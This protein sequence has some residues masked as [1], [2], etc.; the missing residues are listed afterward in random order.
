M[1][2]LEKVPPSHV[3]DF[4]PSGYNDPKNPKK[5][6]I[7][8]KSSEQ[9]KGKQIMILEIE[10]PTVDTLVA[11]P[12]SSVSLKKRKRQFILRESS[13][14]TESLEFKYDAMNISNVEKRVRR[15]WVKETKYI[16][17]TY[18]RRPQTWPLNKLRLKHKL[19]LNPKLKYLVINVYQETPATTEKIK[20]SKGKN[21]KKQR[22]E[23]NQNQ[24]TFKSRLAH[25]Q[26]A[27]SVGNQR[28]KEM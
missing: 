26:E 14:S 16:P 7:S 1:E 20:K 15:K 8:P 21:P 23:V 3:N 25:A 10:T 27:R 11:E 24:S 22:Q 2:V 6:M 5:G 19:I 4:E 18:M 28:A 9:E 17:E 13:Q 12:Y